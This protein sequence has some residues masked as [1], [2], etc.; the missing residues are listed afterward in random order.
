M[1]NVQ[2]A[3][4][5]FNYAN[6]RLSFTDYKVEDGK[7]LKFK[8]YKNG[9]SCNDLKK[10]KVIINGWDETT[11]GEVFLNFLNLSISIWTKIITLL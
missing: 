7:L 1:T 2:C 4:L 3:T 11:Y 5:I 6:L 8:I 9:Q 10:F